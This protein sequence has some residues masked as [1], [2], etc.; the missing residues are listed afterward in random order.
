[1]LERVRR[2]A[3][4]VSLQDNTRVGRPMGR[5]RFR[6]AHFPLFGAGPTE[7]IETSVQYDEVR[8]AKVLSYK[9]CVA[10]SEYLMA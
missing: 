10:G 3:A 7:A 2:F 8:P 4:E 1:M 9:Q 5:H 6:G